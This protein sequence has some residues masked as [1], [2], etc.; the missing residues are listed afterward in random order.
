MAESLILPIVDMR[1]IVVPAMTEPTVMFPSAITSTAPAVAWVSCRLNPV[2]LV[3]ARPASAMSPV[4][5][6][7]TTVLSP[8]SSSFPFGAPPMST[9]ASNVIT[10]PASKSSTSSM[11]ESLMLPIVDMRSIVV[12]AM[13][14]PT[15]MSFS[16]MMS[17]DP[18]VV[19]MLSSVRSPKP[20]NSISPES[21]TA[22]TSLPSANSS[23]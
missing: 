13:T 16:A 19:S 23:F 14:E 18:S 17:I 22:S 10:P 3:S 2:V 4:S 21:D 6:V 1:S 20:L 15:M 9:F 11:A 12:P 5:A 8:A 7:A